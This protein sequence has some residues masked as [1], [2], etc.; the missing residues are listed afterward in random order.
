M[1]YLNITYNSHGRHLHAFKACV[2]SANRCNTPKLEPL[3]SL[4]G[5]NTSILLD[6]TIDFWS[7]LVPKL[8]PM[9]IYCFW[10]SSGRR[11]GE[12]GGDRGLR[13]ERTWCSL[14]QLK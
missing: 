10:A 11:L 9:S 13:F 4:T 6:R 12:T 7:I 8:S 14:S 3:T 1:L 5:T 2:I